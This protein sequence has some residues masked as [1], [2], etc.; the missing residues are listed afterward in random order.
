MKYL[1]FN[2]NTEADS[3]VAVVECS[4]KS[5]ELI[6]KRMSLAAKVKEADDDL[7]WIEF[8]DSVDVFYRTEA[9]EEW[10]AENEGIEDL[11]TQLYVR[12]D[13]DPDFGDRV[14]TDLAYMVVDERSC[15]WMI[16]LKHSD[17]RCETEALFD[18]DFTKWEVPEAG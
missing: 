18:R 5:V 6:R 12:T 7:A 11:D 16:R 15:F 14:R 10:L 17:E 1:I 3:M 4:P 2:V 8:Y 13:K 9:V